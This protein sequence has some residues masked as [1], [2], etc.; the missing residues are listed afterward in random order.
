[1]SWGERK[2]WCSCTEAGRGWHMTEPSYQQTS[3]RSEWWSQV[4]IQEA[5]PPTWLSHL[6]NS[7]RQSHWG[8]QQWM[9]ETEDFFFFNFV[10]LNKKE[11]YEER[12][13]SYI[14]ETYMHR[15][16]SQLKVLRGKLKAGPESHNKPRCT[17]K[18]QLSFWTRTLWPTVQP[19]MFR[20]IHN[21][22]LCLT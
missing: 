10:S 8:R 21:G 9:T 3:P 12:M 16:M 6:Q 20:N 5:A 22:W 15:E 2:T 14:Y 11:Q 4:S 19:S 7:P 18:H 17:S 1:M 13:S